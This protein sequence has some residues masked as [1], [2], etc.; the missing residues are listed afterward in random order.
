M[1]PLLAR[2]HA[3]NRAP[4]RPGAPA[5]FATGRPQRKTSPATTASTP[6]RPA[7]AAAGPGPGDQ[8][9]SVP[10]RALASAFAA[11]LLAAGPPPDAAALGTL[12]ADGSGSVS[13][14]LAP[15]APASTLSLPTPASRQPPLTKEETATVDL[16][17][18]AQA[19]VVWVT[20]LTPRTDPLSQ[21]ILELPQ[22]A[23]SGVIWDGA[24]HIVTNAHVVKGS[25]AVSVKFLSGREARARI[26]G[27]DPG[28]FF[29][30]ESSLARALA[31]DAA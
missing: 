3:L 14:T 15:P 4:L 5:P 26:V 19:G 2:A 22:G 21:A 13:L 25:A 9:P 7:A 1:S 28:E 12:P 10:S 20:S 24:G 18:K 6:P 11:L 30:W 23:G 29:W 16:F 17:R 31:L 27:T 8:T